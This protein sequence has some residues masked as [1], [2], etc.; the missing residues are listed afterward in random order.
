METLL[1]LYER[2]NFRRPDENMG[3]LRHKWAGP[4]RDRNATHN[5]WSQR[6]LGIL[7]DSYKNGL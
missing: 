3:F 6:K 1:E 4:H 5:Y 7:F 2:V